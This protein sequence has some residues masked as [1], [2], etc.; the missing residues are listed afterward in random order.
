[1]YMIEKH[2]EDYKKMARDH[3]NHYQDTPNQIRK[4][5]NLFKKNKLQ[6]QKYLEDKKNGV[7]FIKLF[8]S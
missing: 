4:K 8:D 7:N 1:M 6:Y 2:G 5:I 3:Q